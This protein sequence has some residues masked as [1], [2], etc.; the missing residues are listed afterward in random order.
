MP[1]TS[2]TECP[3]VL[4]FSFC[5]KKDSCCVSEQKPQSAGTVPGF[6]TAPLVS[7]QLILS[8]SEHLWP[9]ADHH[10]CP[11]IFPDIVPPSSL[12]LVS[13]STTCWSPMLVPHK[14]RSSGDSFHHM[15]S[16]FVPG[17]PVSAS[18]EPM[19]MSL[20]VWVSSSPCVPGN[21]PP[22][23]PQPYFSQKRSER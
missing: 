21:T 18:N 17:V 20:P 8:H 6:A 14:R 5:S 4:S 16:Y 10:C 15:A 11:G 7:L 23:P 13:V 12:I 19:L 9:Y 22:P 2:L 3:P 1:N